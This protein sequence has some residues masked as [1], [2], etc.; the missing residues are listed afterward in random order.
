L[1]LQDSQIVTVKS[2]G[3][4]HLRHDLKEVI[5][6]RPGLLAALAIALAPLPGF[7]QMGGM[8]GGMGDGMGGMGGGMMGGMAGMGG[9]MMGGRPWL[10]QERIVKIE[11]VGGQSVSGKLH[12]GPVFVDSDVGQY[13]I[14]PEKVKTIRL[15]KLVEKPATG[16]NEAIPYTTVQG[17]VITSSGKEISGIVR[18]PQ[19]RLEIDD[20][21][22]S[23]V[24][25]KLKTLTFGAPPER[26]P[27]QRGANPRSTSYQH[28]NKTIIMT[29]PAG[30]EVT[31][32]D[33]ATKNK[34]SVQL[35]ESP[36]TRLQVTPIWGPNNAALMLRGPKITRIAAANG[37]NGTWHTQDLREP[38]KGEAMPLVGQGVVAYALGRYIYAY[39]TAAERWDVVE[40]PKGYQVV[41][42]VGANSVTAEIPGHIYT[43]NVQ[44]AKW[45]HVDVHALL[46]TA[47]DTEKD[48]PDH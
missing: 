29:S 13:E 43:F 34:T 17:T 33:L 11:M 30:D 36:K 44:T 12:L 41:P 6:I 45:D 2:G 4:L 24:P 15:S 1:N 8:M 3:D 26:T 38:V 28:L 9:G 47:P 18:I 14:N 23:L 32:L 48:D 39:S 5:M 42:I 21:T 19:W 46:S 31:F 10:E 40:L 27:D 37:L 22:L 25:A 16:E 20:G 35:S 7:A